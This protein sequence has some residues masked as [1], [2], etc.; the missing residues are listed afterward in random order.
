[1][2]SLVG[3]RP[4]DKHE[5][6]DVGLEHDTRLSMRPGL[7]GLWQISART[8]PNFAARVHYDLLYVN[9]WSLALDAK[10]LAKTIPA[11]ILGKGGLVDVTSGHSALSDARIESRSGV[12]IVGGIGTSNSVISA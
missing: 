8:D 7:T 6:P 9:R 3:P 10:I 12:T 2:M 11:V 4:H 1:H 5:L